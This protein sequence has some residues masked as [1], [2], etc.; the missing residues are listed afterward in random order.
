MRSKRCAVQNQGITLI[1][2]NVKLSII[3]LLPD[4]PSI[5][6]TR[7]LMSRPPL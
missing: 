3:D 5:N 7:S 2:Y 1:E 4:L 6:D